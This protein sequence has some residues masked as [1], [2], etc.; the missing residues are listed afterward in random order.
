M[1]SKY[2]KSKEKVIRLRKLGKT[3]GEI[4]KILHQ[5]IP[6]STLSEWCHS[7]YLTSEQ[8]VKIEKAKVENSKRGLAVALIRNKEIRNE[9]INSII[10]ENKNLKDLLKNKDVAKIVL[11]SL[12]MCEGN[13][14]ALALGNSSP[15]IIR[16]FLRL[17]RFCY[18]L[19]EAKFRG[20]VQCRKDQ[21]PESLK[22]F[23][24]KITKIP[25]SQF[26]KPQVDPRTAGKP[27]KNQNYMGVCRINYFSAHIF[28]ELTEIGKILCSAT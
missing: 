14:S 24:S 3:Y 17:L 22:R 12:Y 13:R 8:R 6:K 2:Y 19:D 9:Y 11:A 27:T 4:I 26:Y 23:W 21:N 15:D 25:Q 10:S 16:F 28:T 7:L 18:D 1:K 20:T 5:P